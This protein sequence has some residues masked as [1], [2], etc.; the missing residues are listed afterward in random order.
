MKKS[1]LVRLIGDVL[2]E[3]DVLAGSLAPGSAE[4]KKLDGLRDALDAR[5]RQIVKQIFD[6]NNEKYVNIT[7]GLGAVN[8]QMAGTLQD[9]NKAAQSL[10]LLTK[11]VGLVDEAIGLA[12]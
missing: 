11:F 6:E 4:R 10:E 5:Q 2:T 9:L 8:Q 1:E 12:A 3:M 7:A